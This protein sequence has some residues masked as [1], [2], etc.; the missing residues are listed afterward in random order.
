LKVLFEMG[1]LSGPHVR[2]LDHLDIFKSGEF[3]Q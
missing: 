2:R 1:D 3:G